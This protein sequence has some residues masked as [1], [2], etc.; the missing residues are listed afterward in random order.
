MK[1]NIKHSWLLI[2]AVFLLSACESSPIKTLPVDTEE[3]GNKVGMIA[4][5]FV[6]TDIAGNEIKL[7]AF[8]G[9]VVLLD[10][11]AT[12]CGPCR[13]TVPELVKLWQKYKS[14]DFVIIGVSFDSDKAK[15]LDYIHTN[16]MDWQH[17]HDTGYDVNIN[18]KVDVIPKVFLIDRQGKIIFASHPLMT[19]LDSLVGAVLK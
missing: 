15:L 7:S 16:N 12:W 17:I 2:F 14:E 1:I 10:F 18:Y 3:T 8:R 11:W 13:T 4:P 5:N 19:N 9:K 6:T